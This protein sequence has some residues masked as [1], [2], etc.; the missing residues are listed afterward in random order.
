MAGPK[1]KQSVVIGEHGGFQGSFGLMNYYG[2]SLTPDRIYSIYLA[3][4]GGPPTFLS[5]LE[6]KLGINIAYT[7]KKS[8]GS[9]ASTGSGI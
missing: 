2:M 3:G 4:P 9:A 6:S 8:E 7:S 5:Y 1:G